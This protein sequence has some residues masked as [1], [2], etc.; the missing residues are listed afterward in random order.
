[1]TPHHLAAKFG[2]LALCELIIPEVTNKNPESKN[3]AHDGFTPLH[4]AAQMG[5]VSI[6][7]LIIK[8]H[9]KVLNYKNHPN[10]TNDRG[11]TPLH[12]AAENGNLDV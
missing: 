3:E 6:C 10:P 4:F 2:H 7:E 12:V 8:K 5:H 11:W 9:L 1:M